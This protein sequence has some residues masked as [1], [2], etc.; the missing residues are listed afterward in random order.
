VSDVST[1]DGVSERDRSAAGDWGEQGGGRVWDRHGAGRMSDPFF[2]EGPAV[3]SFSGGRTS[4]YMLRRILNAGLQPDVHVLFANT[5]K[6]RDETLDFI[7]ECETRWAVP[8]H[9]LEYRP[10]SLEQDHHPSQF[11]VDV[12]TY[13]T[14]SRH[15]EPFDR[16]LTKLTFLPNATMRSCT[17]YLKQKTLAKYVKE[18]WGFF[19][20]SS[21]IGIRADEPRRVAKLRAQNDRSAEYGERVLPLADAGVTVD[22]VMAFWA[23]QPFDLQLRP[24]EGNCDLCYLKSTTKILNL[25]RE[26]PDRAVWW[27]DWEQRRGQAFR[28]DRSDYAFMLAQR[29]LFESF[30]D[31]DLIECFCTD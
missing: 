28:K 30:G 24:D 8:V 31:A 14:A 26:Q 18:T 13:H 17:H 2:I 16:L 20:W 10:L 21:V 6:E 5:G 25:I 15:G 19:E 9:W 29:D 4:G 12:V 11:V 7:H 23:T 22:D 27:A 3:I 1:A